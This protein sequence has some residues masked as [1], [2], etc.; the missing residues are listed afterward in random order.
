VNFATH[1]AFE[2]VVLGSQGTF[3]ALR[4]ALTRWRETELVSFETVVGS[5]GALFSLA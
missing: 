2:E 5:R 4:A 3:I 1:I